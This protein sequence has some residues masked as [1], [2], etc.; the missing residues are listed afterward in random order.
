MSSISG[1]GQQQTAAAAKDS[2]AKLTSDF[3]AFLKMLTTQLQNQDPL[4]PMDATQFTQQLVAF[5]QV[6]QQ[7][8]QTGKLQAMLDRMAANDLAN[9]AAFVGRQIEIAKPQAPL[10]ELGASWSYEL[11][12]ASDSTTLEIVDGNGRVVK[13]L[14]GETGSGP[15]WLGWDG[16]SEDGVALPNGAYTLKV[17]AL[18]ASG[19]QVQA[20]AYGQGFVDSAGIVAGSPVLNMGDMSIPLAN[21]RKVGSYAS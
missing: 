12:T 20:G 10:T 2:G 3:N 14:T 11:A 4:K 17:T 8:Q 15:H 6:E 7:I 5:S 16:K 1:V 9:A 13:T 18:T 19:T 21:L